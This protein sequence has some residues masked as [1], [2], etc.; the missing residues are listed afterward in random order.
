MARH[1]MSEADTSSKRRLIKKAMTDA[2]RAHLR[3]WDAARAL[4]DA[5]G[6]DLPEDWWDG[7]VV[8]ADGDAFDA[9]ATDKD[10]DDL[11]AHLPLFARPEIGPE[12]KETA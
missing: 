3:S 11:L 6:T 2:L 4:E 5:I 10:V 1:R 9:E 7:F 8:L 12:E